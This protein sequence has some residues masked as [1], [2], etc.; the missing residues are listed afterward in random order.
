MIT[1]KEYAEARG[2]SVQAVYKAMKAKKNKDRLQ[3]HI[4]RIEG[5]QWLDDTA[6]QI[7]DE[8]RSDSPVVYVEDNRAEQV[9]QYREEVEKYKNLVIELQR[10]LLEKQEQLS[11]ITEQAHLLESKEQE[12]QREIERLQEDLEREQNKTWWAKL[13]GR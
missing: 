4:E 2:K 6:V 7:L 10:Q 1:V 8:S 11:S 9:E 12:R 13:W 3:G 5:K